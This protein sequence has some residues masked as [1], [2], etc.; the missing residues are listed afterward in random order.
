MPQSRKG[1]FQLVTVN[2]A[3]E[4]AKRLI[5]RMIEGLKDRYD[6]EH[7]ANC[8]STHR[9]ASPRPL[10]LLTYCYSDRRSRTDSTATPTSCPFLS[11]NVE[12][13]RSGKDSSNRGKRKTWHQNT[14]NTAR[15]AGRKRTRCS[16]GVSLRRRAVDARHDRHVIMYI[17]KP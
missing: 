1:P 16:G 11:I 4:R 7:V 17:N 14:C 8:A 12:L 3:P 15:L 9:S 5:G 6:I 13:R 10:V 2:T